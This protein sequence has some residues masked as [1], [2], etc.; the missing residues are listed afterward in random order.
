MFAAHGELPGNLEHFILATER[1]FGRS[2]IIFLLFCLLFSMKNDKTIYDR[3]CGIIFSL[4]KLL[5]HQNQAI[6]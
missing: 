3:T 6:R 4:S 1:Y 2:L 5:Q